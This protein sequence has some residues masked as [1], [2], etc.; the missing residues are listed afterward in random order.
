M[1][2]IPLVIYK[3]S[4]RLLVKKN[5]NNWIFEYNIIIE[6]SSKTF[7]KRNYFFNRKKW[8]INKW[9]TFNDLIDFLKQTPT[10]HVLWKLIVLNTTISFDTFKLLRTQC[11]IT[12]LGLFSILVIYLLYLFSNVTKTCDNVYRWLGIDLCYYTLSVILR[13]DLIETYQNNSNKVLIM[14]KT[15]F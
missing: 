15:Y 5:R 11:F 2:S 12:N 14:S 1:I 4:L 8:R 6:Q 7:F 13:L 9:I 10:H 3:H